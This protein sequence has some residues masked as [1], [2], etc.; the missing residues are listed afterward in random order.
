MSYCL[1]ALQLFEGMKQQRFMGVL[2]VVAAVGQGWQQINE[3]GTSHS[4]RPC[5][6]LERPG[7]GLPYP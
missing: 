6:D 3:P 2:I 1:E 7:L 5:R 4:L